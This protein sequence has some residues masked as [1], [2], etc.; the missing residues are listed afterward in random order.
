MI[1]DYVDYKVDVGFLEREKELII[2]LF[3]IVYVKAT[4]NKICQKNSNK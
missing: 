4:D 1:S 3:N 2:H